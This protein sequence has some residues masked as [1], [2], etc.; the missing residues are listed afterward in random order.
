MSIVWCMNTSTKIY[1]APNICKKR[2]CRSNIY[3]HTKVMLVFNMYFVIT[4]NKLKYGERGSLDAQYS[5][6]SSVALPFGFF[7]FFRVI[8]LNLLCCK[9]YCLD[10]LLYITN[11]LLIRSYCLY[12]G[13]YIGAPRIWVPWYCSPNAANKSSLHINKQ[14]SLL[15]HTFILW[16]CIMF[17][18]NNK[19]T[20]HC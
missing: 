20:Q 7:R 8:M 12:L 13:C 6:R 10:L 15:L 3:Y 4:V 2:I 5:W 1:W 16:K 17:K 14:Q 19:C 9:F 11:Y 18:Y